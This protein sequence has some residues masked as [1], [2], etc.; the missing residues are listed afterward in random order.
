MRIRP[1]EVAFDDDEWLAF[2]DTHDFGQLI[3][4]PDASGF[5][6]VV[7][8]HFDL[9]RPAEPSGPT[10]VWLHLATNNHAWP[11][12]QADPRVTLAVV[13]AY[14][15][16]PTAWAAV[17]GQAPTDGVPTS[18]Y[19]AVQLRGRA[20]I[21][22]DATETA[23]V[24]TRLMRRFQPEGGHAEV[25][26]NAGPYAKLLNAIRCAEIEVHDVAAKFKFG[27][28][29]TADHQREIAAHLRE[30]GSP[31][32]VEA[33]DKQLRRLALSPERKQ[34]GSR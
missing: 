17:P 22:A 16:V 15:Y 6:V 23:A 1:D 4:A 2:L 14:T 25:S 9:E 26:P 21:I 19:A 29:R 13:G 34:R 8:V 30:R 11:L 12:I 31:L 33:A 27:G 5:P 20:R 18:Y 32:D 24:L 7:P 28:N 3:T 10:R